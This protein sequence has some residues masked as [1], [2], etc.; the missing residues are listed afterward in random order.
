MKAP[1]LVTSA[2]FAVSED[3]Q[4]KVTGAA[5]CAVSNVKFEKGTLSFDRADDCLP[6][7]V[8]ER[9]MAALKL[10]PV[11]DDVD[12]YELKVAGLKANRYDILIDDEVA[13]TVS[14]EDL[15]KGWNLAV[16]AGPITRQAQ[17][18]LAL[19]FKKNLVGQTLWE[20]K[21]RPWRKKERPGLQK[22]IDDFEAKIAAACQPKPHHF[23]LKPASK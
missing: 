3:Q 6:M 21:L 11:L 15:S 16:A 1:A 19:V 12:R 22:Q 20:A 14:K 10:A 8:D 7:P 13:A 9:A 5:H 23:E 4:G 17:E 18:V 2:E